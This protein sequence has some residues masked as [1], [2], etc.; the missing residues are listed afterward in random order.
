MQHSE[1]TQQEP[2]NGNEEISREGV[3][4]PPT[5]DLQGIYGNNR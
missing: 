4:S 2:Q 1:K 5:G 3:E